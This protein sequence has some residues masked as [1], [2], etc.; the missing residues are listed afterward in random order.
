MIPRCVFKS[1][2]LARQDTARDDLV[3]QLHQIPPDLI[4]YLIQVLRRLREEGRRVVV[5]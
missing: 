4:T 1:S 2:R 5:G 3:T